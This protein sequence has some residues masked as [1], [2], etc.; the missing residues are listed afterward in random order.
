MLDKGREI[1]LKDNMI[2][3]EKAKAEAAAHET[4]AETVVRLET[5]LDTLMNNMKEL[6]E[7]YLVFQVH[8]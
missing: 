8:L 4:H 1:L 5:E 2:D 7:K 6:M 3:E